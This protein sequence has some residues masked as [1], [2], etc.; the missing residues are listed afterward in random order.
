M[1]NDITIASTTPLL[2]V[3]FFLLSR[4]RCFRLLFASV[5]VCYTLCVRC[6]FQS[7]IE[8]EMVL[9]R[10][11]CWIEFFLCRLN[12]MFS[13]FYFNSSFLMY[14]VLFVLV[15][16]L[17]L[18]TVS[19]TVFHSLLTRVFSVCFWLLFLLP[20]V[21]L[22]YVA[23]SLFSFYL[24]DLLNLHMFRKWWNDTDL[25]STL[26]F[27]WPHFSEN[28]KYTH[29]RWKHFEH[30]HFDSYFLHCF[31]QAEVQKRTKNNENAIEITNNSTFSVN[32]FEGK[33]KKMG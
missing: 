28:I 26:P 17:S 33:M 24:F 32:N 15:R 27:E 14:F 5:A 19:A 29:C 4:L 7:E 30:R 21:T 10:F 20:F 3:F 31:W 6:V 9:L 23:F 1:I 2:C 11:K 25:A 22:F 16:F 18:F 12:R 13:A 8:S